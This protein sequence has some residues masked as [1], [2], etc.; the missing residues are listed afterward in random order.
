[1]KLG[2]YSVHDRAAEAYTTP[3]FLPNDDMAMRSF[4]ACVNQPDHHF[5][6]SPADFTLFKVG[7]FDS[8]EGS[9]EHEAPVSLG[10]G[11]SFLTHPATNG[12]NL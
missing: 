5:K 7:V 3:F 12:G 4:G 11:V 8:L 10:N 1:M 6:A 2:I 9:I